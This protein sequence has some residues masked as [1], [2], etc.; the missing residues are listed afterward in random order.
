MKLPKNSPKGRPRRLLGK[1]VN[2]LSSPRHVLPSDLPKTVR[3]LNDRE[4]D[5]LL[6]AVLDEQRRRRRDIS[7]PDRSSGKRRVEVASIPL[8]RVR[9]TQCVLHSKQGSHL[10]GL[11]VNSDYLNPMSERCWRQSDKYT[12]ILNF[13]RAQL[14]LA[15]LPSGLG[16]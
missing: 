15:R 1:A 6:S 2:N 11:L 4:L 13:V 9:S 8:T 14:H 5:R 3:Q 7:V 10:R 12:Q 16:F